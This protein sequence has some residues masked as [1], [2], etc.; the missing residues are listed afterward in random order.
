VFRHRGNLGT[1]LNK[2]QLAQ[3]YRD[4]AETGELLRTTEHILFPLNSFI[5]VLKLN[6][7]IQAA[8]EA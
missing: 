2:K 5:F 1:E 6:F 7:K 3:N 8:F 4:V